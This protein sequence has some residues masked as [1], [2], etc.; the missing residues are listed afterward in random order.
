MSGSKIDLDYP[1]GNQCRK[2]EK[3]LYFIMKIHCSQKPFACHQINDNFFLC[4]SIMKL[5][6]SKRKYLPF[7]IEHA[8]L[9]KEFGIKLGNDKKYIHAC[10]SKFM[11]FNI[12]GDS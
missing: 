11:R 12:Y 7:E 9:G 6:M 2:L 5:I 10:I 4:P 1:H 3:G 8:V